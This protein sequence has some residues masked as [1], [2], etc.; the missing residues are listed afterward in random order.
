MFDHP[1]MGTAHGSR[2]RRQGFTL[3]ELLVV[4]GIIAILIAILLPSLNK[5]RRAARTV[6]CQSNVRQ[7]VMGEM[8][9][10]ADNKYKFSPYYDFGG[11]PPA[12]FQIEWMQQAARPE[13]LNKVRLCP[14][15]TEPNPSYIPAAPPTGNASGPNMPGGAFYCWGP[16]GRAMRYFDS[17]YFATG[18]VQHMS[19]SYTFNGFCLRTHPSGDDSVLVGGN[20]AG[21]VLRLWQPPIKVGWNL[22]IICDGTWPTAWPKDDQTAP[23]SLYMPAGAPTMNIGNNWTRICIARH[24]MA[25]NV[26]FLDGHVA[27]VELPE[28]WKLKWHRIWKEPDPATLAA[29]R[30]DIKRKFTQ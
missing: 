30:D 16:Y 22:P 7:L 14:E 23:P 24:R 4:I 11:L 2:G 5:A 13:Q 29:I 10:L 18:E 3:V 27:T 8:Q 6:Q 17:K 15:A 21:D 28:L 12:P 26:G 1:F 9:Y 19:G 25:I 20:Q